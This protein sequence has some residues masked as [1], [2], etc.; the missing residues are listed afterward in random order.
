MIMKAL[1]TYKVKYPFK[2]VHNTGFD[3]FGNIETDDMWIGGCDKHYEDGPAVF[4]GQCIQEVFYS[5]N[6]EGW[7]IFEILAVA[8]M[9]RK[10]QD[11]ILYRVIL[12]DPERN[13]RKKTSVHCVTKS[14]FERIIDG[15]PHEYEIT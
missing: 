4:E 7:I 1:D 15:Y 2:L 12:I 9:P 5:C 14:K 8:E 13:E 11:R 6:G 10:Y 3:G